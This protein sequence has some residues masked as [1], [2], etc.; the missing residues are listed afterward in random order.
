MAPPEVSTRCQQA[1]FPAGYDLYLTSRAGAKGSLRDGAETTVVVPPEPFDLQL[2]RTTSDGL[3]RE[4]DAGNP[5]WA[6]SAQAGC[7]ILSPT[8]STAARGRAPVRA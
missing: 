8:R 3:A 5:Y 6:A 2:T 7:S 1:A 4:R